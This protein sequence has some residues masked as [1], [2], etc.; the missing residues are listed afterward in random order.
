MNMLVIPT[1][2]KWIVQDQ[3]RNNVDYKMVHLETTISRDP[4]H[5]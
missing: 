4:S 5:N 1:L 3:E 2:G